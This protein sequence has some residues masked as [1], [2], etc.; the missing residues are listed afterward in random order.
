MNSLFVSNRTEAA[1]A[2]QLY[3]LVG[4]LAGKAG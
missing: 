2:D 3:M 4:V 1:A